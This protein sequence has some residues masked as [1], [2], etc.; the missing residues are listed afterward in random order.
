M[1]PSAV[2]LFNFDDSTQRSNVCE[3]TRRAHAHFPFFFATHGE[4]INKCVIFFGLLTKYAGGSWIS[5]MIASGKRA[6]DAAF[7]FLFIGN[8]NLTD[9]IFSPALFLFPLSTFPHGFAL[10][11]EKWNTALF[12]QQNVRSY[13]FSTDSRQYVIERWEIE[14][15]YIFLHEARK[16][17]ISK[18]HR[19]VNTI[20]VWY[21]K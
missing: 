11:I 10:T 6:R 3:R 4:I 19:T 12:Q 8:V 1:N 9:F 2:T 20:Y 17:K 13:F 14:E 5:K 15:K 21:D 18:K 7:I 16:I